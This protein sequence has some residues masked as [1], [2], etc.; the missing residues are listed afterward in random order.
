MF[1]STFNAETAEHAEKKPVCALGELC[2]DRR[3]NFPTIRP[4]TTSVGES[5]FDQRRPSLAAWWAAH[6]QF[7]DPDNCP[8]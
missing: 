8:F 3:H 5:P 7:L 4:R 2:V 1:L 6:P